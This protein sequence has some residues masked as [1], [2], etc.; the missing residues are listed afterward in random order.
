MII[1]NTI[2]SVILLII[3]PFCLGLLVLSKVDNKAKTI[4]LV[5][6]IGYLVGLALFELVTIPILL[7]TE[8]QN[9]Y[10]VCWIY[11]PLVL[12]LAGF[13]LYSS[14]KNAEIK[15]LTRS[16]AIYKASN[17]DGLVM[18]VIAGIILL[19]MLYMAQT[20]VF[21]DGDDAFYVTQ[22]L[23]TSQNGTMYASQAYTGRAATVDIRHAMAVFT[24]WISYIS[25]L[26]GIHSTIVCHTILPIL[27]LPLTVTTYNELGLR[28][29]GE[30]K[31][32][33]PYFAVFI[34]LLI[35]FGRISIYTPE[36]FLL[37]RTWQG[38]AMAANFLIPMTFIALYMVFAVEGWTGWIFLVLANMVAGIFSSLAVVL[39]SI[40][41]LVGGFILSIT[42]KKWK[43]FLRA[44][45]CCIPGGIY[46]ILY[47][48]FTFFG[49]R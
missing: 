9:F 30:K 29:L 20:R 1:V 19:G 27:I 17:I 42:R 39:I 49:W 21:F 12:V 18:W 2:M 11:T 48:Y 36:T 24:M 15:G 25:K 31:E 35:V 5:M 33:L 32:M 34:E 23:I 37:T 46:M 16:I 13:G 14:I 41:I 38:K 10:Y 22:S 43:L 3:I 4:G 45:M 47:L 40:L 26:T 44:C 6:P 8:Y 28:L 7:L